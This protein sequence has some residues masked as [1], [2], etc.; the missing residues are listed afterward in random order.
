MASGVYNFC[1]IVRDLFQVHVM[2]VEYPGYSTVWPAGCLRLGLSGV[3]PKKTNTICGVTLPAGLEEASKL[4]NGAIFTPSTKAEMGA[5]DE[6]I[7]FSA[8]LSVLKELNI[9]GRNWPLYLL[10]CDG[11]HQHQQ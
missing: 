9:C 8:H 7:S 6:N 5:H 11:G 2:A 3:W 10:H 4:P 1:T